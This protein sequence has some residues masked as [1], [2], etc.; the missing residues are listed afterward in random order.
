[1]PDD[2]PNPPT[3]P[4]RVK[5]GQ[6]ERVMLSRQI[7]VLRLITIYFG[8]AA[9]GDTKLSEIPIQARVD[10]LKK[11]VAPFRS[12]DPNVEDYADLEPIRLAIGDARIVDLS[13]QS[14][15]D[16]ATFHARTRLIKFLH[17]KCG[18]DVLAF[19]SGL[20]DCRKAWDLLREGKMPARDAI[21]QGVFGIW[22]GTE[23]LRPIFEYLGKQARQSR[24]LEVCGFDCQFTGP[25]SRRFLPEELTA[26]LKS[27][28]PDSLTQE[29]REAVV[30]GLKKLARPGVGIDKSENEALVACRKA[31]AESKPSSSL[32]AVEL[33][34]WR[35]FLESS[36]AMA[37]VEAATKA[38]VKTERNHINLRDAQMGKNLVWQ[39]REVY[40]KRKII[41]WAAAFHLMRNQEAVA[42]VVE[43]GKTPAER[44][45]VFPYRQ[46]KTMGNEAWRELEKETYSIFFTAAEGEFQSLP[47]SKPKKL[48][49]LIPGSLEDLLVK[50]GSE[51]GFLDLRRRGAEGRWLEERLVAR[52]LGNADYEA[53]WTK[54]CDGLVF[55]RKQFGATPVKIDM[56]AVKYQPVLDKS[57][58]G[59][60]FER[61]TT[62]DRFDRTITF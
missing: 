10:W 32:T 43:P 24:P 60:P 9:A 14:H 62:R 37:E 6:K 4:N 47:M 18:F 15:G 33:A 26:V 39:A 27:L 29:Q 58:L 28:P 56:T 34:F 55:T 51:N 53:D 16:G 59:V 30:K 3:G 40:P 42:M 7:V 48:E 11:H 25:A 50:A 57:A 12:I 36:I 13:E 61:Y 44:K 45:T 19:E 1:M 31:L 5:L 17:Q 21:S 35:Q 41:V 52:V 8:V 23:E 46:I 49:P 54:V 2:S 38:G 22:T 20:Y